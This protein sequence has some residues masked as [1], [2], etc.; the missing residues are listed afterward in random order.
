[1]KL[2]DRPGW[3]FENLNGTKVLSRISP[4]SMEPSPGPSGS[5]KGLE[6]GVEEDNAV[7]GVVTHL[8]QAR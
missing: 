5:S 1:M 4:S 6:T 3:V 2:R 7:D 8:G